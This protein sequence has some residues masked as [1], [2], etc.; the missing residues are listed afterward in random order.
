M[1]NGSQQLQMDWDFL[2]R[3]GWIRNANIRDGKAHDGKTVLAG[4]ICHLL[5]LIN[6]HLGKNSECWPNQDTLA[7]LMKCSKRTVVRATQ[8]A[9]DL[10]LITV[11]NKPYGGKGQKKGNHYRI[12]WS[13]LLLLDEDRARAFRDSI[14]GR[15]GEPSAAEC[16]S[17]ERSDLGTERS[18]LGTERSDLGTERS[19]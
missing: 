14:A 3:Q 15:R 6:E 8:A 16:H 18:D 17:P 12:I 13:E 10:N 9:Q 4:R 19:D 2:E 5:E 1:R 11:Q 7:K